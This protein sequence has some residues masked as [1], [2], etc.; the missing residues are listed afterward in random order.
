MP[1]MV[2]PADAARRDDSASLVATE[3]EAHTVVS[4]LLLVCAVGCDAVCAVDLPVGAVDCPSSLRV[5]SLVVTAMLASPQLKGVN[6]V[7][8]RVFL[9]VVLLLLSFSGFHRGSEEMRTADCVFTTLV[10][11]M[12]VQIYN[13]GGI[14]TKEVR[15]D[16][17]RDKP[18]R[19]QT[20]SGL[21]AALMV[22]V[23]ARGLR[24]AF[25]YA[26]TV[27]GYMVQYQTSETTIV[28]QGYAHAT[29]WV[30]A[31][32]G[33]GYGVVLFA[34][35]LIGLHGETN[36][37]GSL[38]VAFEIGFSGVAV[39]VAALW[40]LIGQSFSMKA[41]DFLYGS[42][43]CTGGE[44]MCYEAARARRLVVANGCTG[45]LWVA[46]LSA[47]MFSFAVER[48]VWESNPV[49]A[50]SLWR[51]EG[52]GIALA[53]AG[54]AAAAVVSNTDL[55]SPQWHTEVCSVA[56]LLGVFVS[57]V[58]DTFLGT[59]IY[60]VAMTYE[61]WMLLDNYGASKVFVHLT[62]CTIF[63]S[64]LCVW[65][66]V[67]LMGIKDLLEGRGFQLARESAVNGGLGVVVTFGTSLTFGLYIASAILLSASTGR[68]PQEEEEL[69]RGGSPTRSMIAF[70][71]DHF[72]PLFVWIPLYACRCE[73]NLVSARSR[74]IAWLSALP[75][76]A[77][78]YLIVLA[79]LGKSAPTAS[80]MQ[81]SGASVV[82]AAS[83]LT[84][85]VA[86][87]G[88]DELHPKIV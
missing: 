2:V 66:Q 34:G 80:I 6:L 70:A 41:L 18:H 59:V 23:G 48:R 16:S 58:S 87:G 61:Q 7:D 55:E 26:N 11:L 79:F 28:S 39:C 64:L 14:E 3:V 36:T 53:L 74:S 35:M 52:A 12:T 19:R 51:R 71:L 31:P 88:A 82:T 75:T 43:A 9:G 30:S 57:S 27:S 60:A 68:V 22:Y 47:L 69:F 8:Q 37:K 56:C 46:G 76:Q 67:V 32:L 83:I 54:A 84:W 85:Y 81:R 25:V 49:S 42:A 44:D 65:V 63:L 4:A 72:L 40:A 38:A 86:G 10:L 20:I 1:T 62:H 78:V 5:S 24:D 13:A 17:V 33:V 29:V 15:P 73:V 45:P 50:V 77:V 21:C